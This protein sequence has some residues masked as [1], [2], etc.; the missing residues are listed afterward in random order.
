MKVI[1][2]NIRA[3]IILPYLD[4]EGSIILEPDSILNKGTSHLLSRPI[5][6][7]LIQWHDMQPEDATWES[8][9]QIQQQF[10]HINL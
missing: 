2:T 4:N 6:G 10:P 9:V 8:L 7:V 3:Q 5:T 1:G